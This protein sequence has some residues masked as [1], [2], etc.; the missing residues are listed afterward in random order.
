[1]TE[2]KNALSIDAE[3]YYMHM[4]VPFDYWPNYES[5]LIENMNK[6]IQILDKCRVRATFFVL[7]W[8]AEKY[9]SIVEAVSERGHE[10]ACHGYNHVPIYRQTRDEFWNDVTKSLKI[11]EKTSGEKVL[12]Y[13]APYFSVTAEC[14]WAINILEEL[15]LKYDSSIFPVKTH[16]YGAPRAPRYIYKPSRWDVSS[17]DDERDFIEFPLSTF[18]LL[19]INIPVCGGFY[20]RALPYWITKTGIRQINKK[21]FPA[22]VYFHPYEL[23]QHRHPVKLPFNEQFILDFNLRSM[24]K[25]LRRLIREI[26]FTM[27]REVLSV[28]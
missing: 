16:H 22:I 24:E 23:E 13:R 25:K 10:V 11:L 28:G 20:L 15:G 8:V 9:P 12:G 26:K 5:H 17:V 21:G 19:G 27:I 6:I 18:R 2:L 14:C 3:E 4:A 7:G 1:M